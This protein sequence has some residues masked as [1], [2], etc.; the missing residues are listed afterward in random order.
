[1]DRNWDE[2]TKVLVQQVQFPLEENTLLKLIYPSLRNNTK[3][4]TLPTLCNYGK[5]RLCKMEFYAV[6]D[7][8]GVM[9]TP[10]IWLN[11]R[12]LPINQYG[13]FTT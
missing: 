1:M 8:Q 9:R 2:N 11:M 3:M 12:K 6:F 13:V 7:L 10:Q 5:T 4:T